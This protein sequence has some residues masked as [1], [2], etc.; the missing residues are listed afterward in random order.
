M[1]VQAMS[2]VLKGEHRAFRLLTDR[3]IP[4]SHFALLMEMA[5]GKGV[6]NP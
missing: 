2:G 3:H 4:Q 5:L 1:K 6:D